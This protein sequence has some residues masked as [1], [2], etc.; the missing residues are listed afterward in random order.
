MLVLRGRHGE[1]FPFGPDALLVEVTNPQVASRLTDVLD[2]PEPYLR[3]ERFWVFLFDASE[4]EKV[5]KVIRPW[6]K[7]R[8][9]AL[10]RN[11]LAE[12]GRDT[13]FQGAVPRH[14]R[15]STEG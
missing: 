12:A 5:A 11:R 9:S 2:T 6:R 8:L 3:G 15:T 7:R 10:A 14:S 13:R 1:A 4:L